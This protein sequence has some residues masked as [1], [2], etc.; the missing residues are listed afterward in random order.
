MS[1][2]DRSALL[3]KWAPILEH[4]NLPAFKDQYKKEVTAVLLENQERESAKS[5][6][7]LFETHANAIG[8]G[9]DTGGVAKFDPVLIKTHKIAQEPPK[10]RQELPKSRPELSKSRPGVPKT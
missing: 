4:A 3:K 1:N 10:S 2:L 5:Q 9:P 6:E 8:A 7:V